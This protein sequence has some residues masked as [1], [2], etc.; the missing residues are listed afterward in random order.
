MTGPRRRPSRS[1]NPTPGPLSTAGRASCPRRQCPRLVRADHGRRAKRLDGGKPAN[2]RVASGHSPHAD[3]QRNRHHGRQCFGNRRHRQ[4]KARLD[5]R[6]REAPCNAPSTDTRAA[7]A[8]GDPHQP[9]AERIELSLEW[10]VFL[11]HRRRPACRSVR[12]RCAAPVPVTTARPIPA[13]TAALLNTMLARSASGCRVIQH[14]VFG[15]SRPGSDSPVSAAS[16]T[17]RSVAR[18]SRAS[19]GTRRPAE[20]SMRSPGTRRL[21]I[22]DLQAGHFARPSRPRHVESPQRVHRAAGPP[23]G[24]KAHGRVDHKHGRDSRSPR[25]SRRARPRWSPAMRE[26]EHDDARQLILENPAERTRV[27][28][29]EPVRA[30]FH[31]TRAGSR[32]GQSRGGVPAASSTSRTDRVCQG[33]E[34][35]ASA[36]PPHGGSGSS[37]T[38]RSWQQHS[39]SVQMRRM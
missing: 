31:E 4:C 9:A 27:S 15:S 28:G 10:R 5:T 13:I 36:G 26:Q 18:I 30:E 19:A 34:G 23:L 7:T 2:Q 11:D 32:P 6:A 12:P 3:R 17:R 35:P 37:V 1:R 22:D 21:G 8:S 39:R 14:D 24:G 16:I 29:T 20:I 38:S 25:D 33:R